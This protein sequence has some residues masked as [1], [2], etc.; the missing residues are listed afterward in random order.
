MACGGGVAHLRAVRRRMVQDVCI[1]AGQFW[2]VSIATGGRCLGVDAS[3][4]PARQRGGAKAAREALSWGRAPCSSRCAPGSPW[5]QSALIQPFR[6]DA[7]RTKREFV[8]D[9]GEARLVIDSG[10]ATSQQMWSA[11]FAGFRAG[12]GSGM[13]VLIEMSMR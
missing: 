12:E 7:V 8:G 4:R 13:A 5:H 11:S 9:R 6:G 1:S 3:A 2:T 10:K